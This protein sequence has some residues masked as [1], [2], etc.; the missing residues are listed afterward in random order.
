VS[1]PETGGGPDL[2]RLV[3]GR[4]GP[5]WPNRQE[6]Q[7]L[8]FALGRFGEPLSRFLL[9]GLGEEEETP[10]R[11]LFTIAFSDKQ[12]ARYQRR[13]SVTA[14]E[15]AEGLLPCLPRGREPLA[16]LAFLHLLIEGRKLSSF[17][18]KYEQ[19]EVLRLLGWDD[20]GEARQSLDDV[21]GRYFCLDY[22]WELSR[23]E[24]AA[25]GLAFY[26]AAS[27]L[28]SESGSDLVWE[29]GRLKRAR[30]EVTFSEVFVTELLR[31]SLFGVNWDKVHKVEVEDAD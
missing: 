21:V 28:V 3:R 19:G 13:V 8:K 22:R 27:R 31:R 29:G 25:Q 17:V 1:G 7:L 4:G 16:L 9:T 10:R 18:L 14:E 5:L 24:L 15:R 12:G 6:W 26:N 20:A 23:E 30:C 11:R 2:V